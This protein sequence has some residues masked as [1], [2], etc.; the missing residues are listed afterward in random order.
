MGIVG[1]NMQYFDWGYI[2]WIYEPDF[3]N[4]SN[5][6]SIGITTILPHKRQNKH[7]HYG[8]EQFI[9]VLSG[10]GMQLIGDKTSE[11]KPK[12]IYHME[13]GIIHETINHGDKP[14]KHLLI[15]IPMNNESNIVIQKEEVS[16]AGFGGNFDETIKVNN[17]IQ[18]IYDNI[19]APLNMPVSIFDMEG[20]IVIQGKDYPQFC[21]SKCLTDGINKNCPMYSLKG[22]YKPPHYTDLSAFICPHGLTVVNTPIMMNNK[23]IGIIKGGHIKTS[24]DNSYSNTENIVPKGTVNAVLQQLKKLNRTIQNYYIFKDAEIKLNKKEEIIQDIVKNEVTLEETLKSARE[25]VLNIQISN[26]FL[27]NTLNA[28][29][30]MAIKENAVETYQSIIDISKMLR[31]TSTND[32]QFVQLKNEFQYLQNYTNLQKLRYRERLHINLDISPEIDDKNIPFNCLQPIVEN[33]FIHGFKDMKQGMEIN[34]AAELDGN[35]IIIEIIDNGNGMN[36]EALNKLREKI[37][38][39]EKNELRGLMMIFSKLKLFYGD[40]FNFIIESSE[41]RGTKVKIVLPEYFV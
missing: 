35:N 41:G 11:M 18:Y 26:H 39:Y 37:S 20:N 40:N 10:E 19:A 5:N 7:I 14:I 8:N 15:A 29:A 21:K 16:A 23:P 33:C 38:E 25:K 27:F 12:Q 24:K 9:Y 32:S 13:A 22:E 3:N 31:Y 2:E 4:T 36:Q 6:M 17:E 30:G 28:L 34:I 1:K